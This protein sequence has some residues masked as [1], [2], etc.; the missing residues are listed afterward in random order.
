MNYSLIS[1]EKAEQSRATMRSVKPARVI[2]D[3]KG[4]PYTCDKC[5]QVRWSKID[6]PIPENEDFYI[7]RISVDSTFRHDINSD[8]HNNSVAPLE[9]MCKTEGPTRVSFRSSSVSTDKWL[10]CAQSRGALQWQ[11]IE[12]VL[13][14]TPIYSMSTATHVQIE[15][16][17]RGTI[18]NNAH[19]SS[20]WSGGFSILYGPESSIRPLRSCEPLLVQ[21]GMTRDASH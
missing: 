5:I 3:Y 10:T 2:T 14:K 17:H 1:E 7:A 20:S 9:L 12:R 6:S 16:E 15:K 13:N 4:I 8:N 21:R 19:Q 18:R 11:E